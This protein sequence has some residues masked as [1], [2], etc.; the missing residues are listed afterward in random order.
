MD[1]TRSGTFFSH[2]PI[3][4]S[5]SGDYWVIGIHPKVGQFQNTLIA[6]HNP[7]IIATLV[8]QVKKTHANFNKDQIDKFY[9]DGHWFIA[10][11]NSGY[12]NVLNK[13]CS[14]HFL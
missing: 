12:G 11:Q 2:Q 3:A 13:T 6:L 7:N 1:E 4:E 10:S 14:K 5:D 9:S 8:L